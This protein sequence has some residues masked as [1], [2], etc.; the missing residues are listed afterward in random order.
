MWRVMVWEVDS[1]KVFYI[2][3]VEIIDLT[4]P[5]INYG[6][7]WYHV[8]PGWQKPKHLWKQVFA[9]PL[10]NNAVQLNVSYIHTDPYI[11][12]SCFFNSSTLFGPLWLLK[13][14]AWTPDLICFNKAISITEATKAIN[15]LSV[16]PLSRVVVVS[17]VKSNRQSVVVL[18]PSR[19]NSRIA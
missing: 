14:P 12:A 3:F 15:F 4:F 13:R 11:K 19:K 7:H 9:F 16:S 6:C 2:C 10:D 17:S 18:D 5:Y 1:Q 8:L